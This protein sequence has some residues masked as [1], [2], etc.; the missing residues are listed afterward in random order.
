MT[1]EQRRILIVTDAWHPQVNGVVRTLDTTVR[2]LQRLGHV[3]GVLEPSRFFRFPCPFYREVPISI[4]L[5]SQVSKVLSQFEPDSIHI[6]TEGSLGLAIRSYCIRHRLAFTTSYTTRSPEYLKRMIGF[7]LRL[8]YAYLRWFHR[9]SAAMM[10][11]T[12]S[13]ATDL[14]RRNFRV[15]MRFWSRGVDLSLF[16]P[17]PKTWPTE[18][19]PVAMYVGRVSTEKGIEDFLALKLPGKKYVVGD[20]PTRPD[21]QARYPDTVFLGYLRG[22]ALAEAYANADVFVFPSRTDTFGLVLIEAMASGVPVAAYPTTGPIDI[23]T[24]E[25]TGALDED[26]GRAV[27]LALARGV[28]AACVEA[29][30]R[31]TW[32]NCTKQFLGN[33]VNVK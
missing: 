24:D 22:E 29:A 3:V 12:P 26:L 32:E 15:P 33:L 5:R 13:L 11:A 21:L 6:A 25:H 2:E 17:R 16:Y 31:Y 27:E 18:H 23:V 10:V 7:P 9:R 19:R 28:P 1:N 4:P 8:S 20:G 30:R 14:R